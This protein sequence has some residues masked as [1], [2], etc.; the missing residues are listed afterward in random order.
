M[1]TSSVFVFAFAIGLV[2]GLRSLTAPAVVS[3][4]ANL[5]WLDLQNSSLVWL[6]MATAAWILSAV[7]I[8]EIVV[9]KLPNTPSQPAM[10]V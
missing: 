6:A 9:D 4:A 10:I 3:W 7:A 1:E 2:A 8:A 5:K